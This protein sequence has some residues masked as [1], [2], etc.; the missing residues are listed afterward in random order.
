MQAYVRLIRAGSA[1]NPRP[2]AYMRDDWVMPTSREFDERV[3]NLAIRFPGLRL[4]DIGSELRIYRGHAGHA[5]AAI[6]KRPKRS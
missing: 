3:T 1:E 5:A 2:P 6:Q 4:G